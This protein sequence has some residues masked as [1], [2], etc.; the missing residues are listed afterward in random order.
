MT[1]G[2]GWGGPV[3]RIDTRSKATASGRGSEN[4]GPSVAGTVTRPNVNVSVFSPSRH[5]AAGALNV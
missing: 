3:S 1:G 5:S 4:G 2:G